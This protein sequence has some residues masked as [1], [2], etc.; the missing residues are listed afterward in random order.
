MM[1]GK[2]MEKLQNFAGFALIVLQLA[3]T[4]D[5]GKREMAA[6]YRPLVRRS[7]PGWLVPAAHRSAVRESAGAGLYLR[8]RSSSADLAF[9]TSPRSFAT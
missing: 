1:G 8:N 4:Q 2:A 5:I 6:F 9:A 7:R 3:A